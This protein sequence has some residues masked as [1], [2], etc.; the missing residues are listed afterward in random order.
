[1]RLAE[2]VDEQPLGEEDIVDIVLHS[3]EITDFFDEA[4]YFKDEFNEGLVDDESLDGVGDDG[5]DDS[6]D[7]DDDDDDNDDDYE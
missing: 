2:V 6:S 4:E 7:D 3:G 1:M 5:G